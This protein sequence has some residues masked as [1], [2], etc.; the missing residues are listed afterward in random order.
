MAGRGKGDAMRHKIEKTKVTSDSR[1][2]CCN[3]DDK[4]AASGMRGQFP[5]K[6]LISTSQSSF[7]ISGFVPA[8]SEA[9]NLPSF[10]A[11]CRLNRNGTPRLLSVRK[12]EHDCVSLS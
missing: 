3:H 12:E 9:E 7:G 1:K 6:R 8:R 11:S 10:P 4:V 5:T 2:T